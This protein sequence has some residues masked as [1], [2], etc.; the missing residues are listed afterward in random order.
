MDVADPDDF[1]IL[2]MKFNRKGTYVVVEINDKTKHLQLVRWINYGSINHGHW[3][4][5][6]YDTFWELNS[7]SVKDLCR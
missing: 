3:A 2:M 4:I 6:D 1:N 7:Q 5:M